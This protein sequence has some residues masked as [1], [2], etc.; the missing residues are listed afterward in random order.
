[1]ALIP[2]NAQHALR[3]LAGTQGR[4]TGHSYE[5]DLADAINQLPL[6][7]N[8]NAHLTGNVFQV[9]SEALTLISYIAQTLN[10][11][12]ITQLS[13]V[14][15]GGLATSSKSQGV[16]F[17]GQNIKKCKSDILIKINNIFDIGVSI[18]QCNNRVPTNAQVYFTTASGFSNLLRNN[19]ISVSQTA[20][21]ALKQFCG[22]TGFTPPN[23]SRYFWEEINTIGRLEWENTFSTYQDEI[24]RILLQKAYSN[25]PFAPDFLLHKTKKFTVTNREIAIYS[26]DEL[27]QKSKYYGSFSTRKYSSRGKLHLAPRFG[28]FQMQRAGNKQHPTQLQFNLKA[29][30][31]Y[32]I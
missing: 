28:I 23:A 32:V 10:I 2:I 26:I 3:I 8:I 4:N 11:H 14:A 19:Q 1:M 22:D 9:I 7:I 20:E 25:D 12:T 17:N 29:G 27:I 30:Y 24:S 6:P 15:T 18:K 31:F 5:E 16:L 21:N 13:A